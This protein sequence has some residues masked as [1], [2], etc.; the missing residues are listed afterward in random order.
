MAAELDYVPL[1]AALIKQ[2]RVTWQAVHQ[3]RTCHGQEL[4]ACQSI[5]SGCLRLAMRERPPSCARA[6]RSLKRDEPDD[7]TP[8]NRA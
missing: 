7:S 2:V 3:G 6:A 1:P 8:R 4:S 5:V